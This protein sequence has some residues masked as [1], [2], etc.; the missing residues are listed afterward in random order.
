[1]L[2][3]VGIGLAV[4]AMTTALLQSVPTAKSGTASGML[5]TV[6]QSGG[7]IGV[8]LFG[9][10]LALGTI[11]GMRLAFLASAIAVAGSAICAFLFIRDADTS[12]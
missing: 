2:F 11:D 6:R 8:A 4:P 7:A 9:S 12:G 5:N 3:P 10:A 1:M